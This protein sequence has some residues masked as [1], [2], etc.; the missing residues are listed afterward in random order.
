MGGSAVDYRVY[1]SAAA[2]G[3]VPADGV[4]AA[5]TQAAARNNSDPYYA[6]FLGQPAP[7]AQLALYPGQTGTANNGTLAFAWHDVIIEKLGNTVTWSVDG[8]LLATVD[9]SALTLAG[10][11]ILFNHYDTNAAQSTDPNSLALLFTLIDNVR[12]IPEP[13]TASVLGIGLALMALA[14]RR[15]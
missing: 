4:F 2:I 11:N 12:V 9:A 13:T 6:S 3:Y 10:G 7:A 14:R 15:R 1:S 8:K 5:G